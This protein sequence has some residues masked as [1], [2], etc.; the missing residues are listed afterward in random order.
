MESRN[1]QYSHAMGSAHQQ[2]GS[3]ASR[4]LSR[5]DA[6]LPTLPNDRSRRHFLNRHIEGWEH[7]YAR[8][9]ATDGASELSNSA[10]L[11]QAADFLLT[12]AGLA[13]RRSALPPRSG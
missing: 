8:F 10:D 9:L 5:L 3:R 4:L 12:I 1:G 6:Y 7:R 2:V 13:R 11:P